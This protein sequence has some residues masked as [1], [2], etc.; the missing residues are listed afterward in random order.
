MALLSSNP[1]NSAR[2]SEAFSVAAALALL[3]LVIAACSTEAGETAL[4]E[5]TL[6][7]G[8]VPIDADLPT[9]AAADPDGEGGVARGDLGVPATPVAGGG[10]SPTG[11][12]AAPVGGP[13]AGKYGCSETISRYVNGSYE[14]EFEGRGFITLDGRG[15]YID[16]FDV[17][18]SYTHASDVDETRF[19]GGALDGAVG[20][21]LEDEG[22][23]LRVVIP[24]DSGERRWTCSLT[25]E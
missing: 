14:F 7:E 24:T 11:N 8:S 18:G 6:I 16:P 23:R 12:P 22:P 9:T 1:G 13:P 15:G 5:P 4:G 3:A 25:D 17:A 19:A 2:H 20:T 10:G 21:P